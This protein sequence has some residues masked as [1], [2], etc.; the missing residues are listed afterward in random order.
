M[1]GPH[2][3]GQGWGPREGVCQPLYLSRCTWDKVSSREKRE[4]PVARVNPTPDQGL[5]NSLQVAPRQLSR[6]AEPLHKT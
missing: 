4:V 5:A 1:T 3:P 6:L 2:V